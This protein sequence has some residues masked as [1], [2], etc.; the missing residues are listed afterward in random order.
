MVVYG[1]R[2][3]TE[4]VSG[5]LVVGA[6]LLLLQPD[7]R[8]A[9]L[10]ALLAG[11]AVFLRYQNGL[12][13]VGLLVLLLAQKRRTE[14]LAYLQVSVAVGLAGGA[15][16][17]V[18]W[19]TPFKSFLEY[20]KFNLLEGKSKQ[21]GVSAFDFYA[22]S[23]WTSTG[24]LLALVLAGLG[25]AYTRARGLVLLVGAFVLAHCFIPH[26]EYRFLM[27]VLPLLLGLTGAGLGRGLQ[28]LALPRWPAVALACSFF[29][30]GI[31]QA[32]DETFG[33][34]GQYTDS[35][36]GQRSVW[37][38]DEDVNL[39]LL[40]ASRREDLCGM[41]VVGIH[42]AWMGG[43]TYLHRDVPF[44]FRLGTAELQQANY[45]AAPS[46]ARIP[47]FDEVAMHDS[48]SIF[49]REGP[50]APRPAGWRPLLP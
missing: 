29:L 27:P 9:R 3:M 28:L 37:H 23:A 26:K 5:P 46:G 40:D 6:A 2:C 22:T 11:L 32:L 4:T 48:F 13:A 31:P 50:C 18:T 47:G 43:Y 10:A 14:A 44:Y 19:G 49:R 30:V 15:L 7:V 38:A 42:P 41:A 8:R 20:V 24:P 33:R 16:D 39:C 1:A 45:V 17:W 35:A 25:L 12:I 34:M 36:N 21:W